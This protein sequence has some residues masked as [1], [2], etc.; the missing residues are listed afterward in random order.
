MSGFSARLS[1]ACAGSRWRSG[2]WLIAPLVLL[3]LACPAAAQAV[4]GEVSTVVQNGYARLVF[5]LAQEI[6]SQVKVSNGILII[7]FEKPVDI[8][9]DRLDGG[10]PDYISAARRDPDGKGIRIALARKATVNS[11]VAAERL[12]VD[13]LPDTWTGL[14]PGLPRE[15]I[16]ELA[17]RAREAEKKLRQ[18]RLL[19]QQNATAAIRVRA[20][21]Q[22]TF[23]RYVFPLPELIG[24]TA[25]NSKDK[26]TLTFGVL[27]KFDL[28]DAKAT[29]PAMITAIDSEAAQDAATVRFSFAGKVDVRTFREDKNYIVDVSSAER[30]ATKSEGAVRSDQLGALAQEFE[31]HPNSA[32][33]LEA[34]QSV[35]A[36]PAAAA[37][38]TPIETR[39]SSSRPV[40]RSPQLIPHRP[41]RVSLRCAKRPPLRR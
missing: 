21:H 33:A 24:V 15:V 2:R 35:P 4:K 28:A 3:A 41:P 32:P 37:A 26:L 29:L 8:R 22:P 9:V 31:T 11:M 19:A 40:R 7:T 13:L 27:L 17:R 39:P 5:T 36:R 12:Y 16:E 10:A 25:D 14:P 34:P 1:R 30:K 23:S 38:K 6:Q 18:Q 20:S